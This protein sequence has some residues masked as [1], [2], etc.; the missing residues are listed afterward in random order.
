MQN[1]DTGGI[2]LEH[3]RPLEREISGTTYIVT[4]QFSA[5]ARETAVEKM[6]RI[7]LKESERLSKSA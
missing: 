5:T 1:T 4:G 3:I 2:R 6:Q 7:I